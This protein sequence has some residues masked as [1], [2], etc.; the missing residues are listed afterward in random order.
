MAFRVLV[1]GRYPDL[2]KHRGHGR[3]R[4]PGRRRRGVGWGEYHG[5]WPGLGRVADDSGYNGAAV[6]GDLLD[7]AFNVCT[8]PVG[9]ASRRISLGVGN[10]VS[11]GCYTIRLQRPIGCRLRCNGNCRGGRNGQR[12]TL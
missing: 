8:A 5:S 9:A 10:L 7:C 11:D 4:F 2:G 6:V 1:D 3:Q 12:R